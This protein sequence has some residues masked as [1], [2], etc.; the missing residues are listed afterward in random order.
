MCT[1]EFLHLYEYSDNGGQDDPDKKDL[2]MDEV[3][4]EKTKRK[5][6]SE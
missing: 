4:A 5:I 3:W 1:I 6:S 2:V